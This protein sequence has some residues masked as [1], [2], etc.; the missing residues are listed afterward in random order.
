MTEGDSGTLMMTSAE[1]VIHRRVRWNVVNTHT[2]VG[3]KKI[4]RA[5]EA[6]QFPFIPFCRCWLARQNLIPLLHNQNARLLE[7]DALI[8]F[9]CQPKIRDGNVYKVSEAFRFRVVA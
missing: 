6:N 9:G 7:P 4:T 8:F 1:R 2:A 3:D 5:M